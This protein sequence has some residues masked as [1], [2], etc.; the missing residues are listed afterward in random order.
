MR[1]VLTI[2]TSGKGGFAI[3]GDVKVKK[4]AVCSLKRNGNNIHGKQLVHTWNRKSSA[5]KI[6]LT[7]SLLLTDRNC[8]QILAP[9]VG[10]DTGGNVYKE[11]QHIGHIARECAEV[12]APLLDRGFVGDSC[13]TDDFRYNSGFILECHLQS[14]DS[15][16]SKKG[17]P[18]SI[19]VLSNN[20]A[21]WVQCLATMFFENGFPPIVVV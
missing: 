9:L 13:A 5:A 20:S 19:V 12:L 2:K 10:G 16:K 8:I 15:N 21:P 3:L 1:H 7:C 4:G 6:A 17:Y 18:V 11:G 14:T